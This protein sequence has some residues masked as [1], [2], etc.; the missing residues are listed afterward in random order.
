MKNIDWK[1]FLNRHHVF[2]TLKEKEIN[3]LLEVSEEKDCPQGSVILREGEFGDSIFLI[4][5]G[6][7]QIVLQGEQPPPITLSILKKDRDQPR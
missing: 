5:S 3:R 6:S 1:D 7:V 2:W 4:G